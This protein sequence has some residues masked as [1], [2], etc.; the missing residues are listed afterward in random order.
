MEAAQSARERK[1]QMLKDLESKLLPKGS[2]GKDETPAEIKKREK[3]FS[4]YLKLQGE[5]DYVSDLEDWH[6]NW[7][8]NP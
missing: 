1:L 8:P 5:L 6:T 3:R 7:R 2:D 4:D